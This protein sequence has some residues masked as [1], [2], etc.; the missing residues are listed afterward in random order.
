MMVKQY[1]GYEIGIYFFVDGRTGKT[2]ISS[3]WKR[4]RR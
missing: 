3:I 2:V 4:E 1:N